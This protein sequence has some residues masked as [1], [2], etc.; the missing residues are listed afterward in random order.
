MGVEVQQI[1]AHRSERGSEGGDFIIAQMCALLFGGDALAIIG[2][3]PK[4]GIAKGGKARCGPAA[5]DCH[6]RQ[7]K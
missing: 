3:L 2:P 1:G 5:F 4:Q 7:N 6:L